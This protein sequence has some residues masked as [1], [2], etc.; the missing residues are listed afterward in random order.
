MQ[1]ASGKRLTQAAVVRLRN[2]LALNHATGT[3]KRGDL[4]H[5]AAPQ[6]G[7]EAVGDLTEPGEAE[8]P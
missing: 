6:R 1:T 7:S 2:C 3:S 4:T 5:S 8:R